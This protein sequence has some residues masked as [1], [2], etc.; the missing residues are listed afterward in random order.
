MIVS[1]AEGPE[2]CILAVGTFSLT[3]INYY[4]WSFS[5][6]KL[7]SKVFSRGFCFCGT[8]FSREKTYI[9][10]QDWKF[11]IIIEGTFSKLWLN[12]AIKVESKKMITIRILFRASFN[13]WIKP[14]CVTI[15]SEATQGLFFH[16]EVSCT[17]IFSHIVW[18]YRPTEMNFVPK[19]DLQYPPN[20]SHLLF[21]KNEETWWAPSAGK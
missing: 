16:A 21:Y 14:S 20:R 17:P 12:W 8:F 10:E 3:I 9:D 19:D 2:R 1:C 7:K 4:G 11:C 15:Y 13:L 18:P 6:K 5:H